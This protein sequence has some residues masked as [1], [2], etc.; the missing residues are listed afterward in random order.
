LL[1]S[2]ICLVNS[3]IW[4]QIP[5][6]HCLIDQVIMK[7]YPEKIC[8]WSLKWINCHQGLTIGHLLPQVSIMLLR[9]V[10]VALAMMNWIWH[11]HSQVVG[12]HVQ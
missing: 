9:C 5:T 6:D 12:I 4:T 10:C 7:A 1:T 3:R 11:L 8:S 2:S